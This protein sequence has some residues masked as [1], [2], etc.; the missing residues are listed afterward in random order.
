MTQGTSIDCTHKRHKYTDTWGRVK[1]CVYCN[2]P[3]PYLYDEN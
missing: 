1:R 2:K 3:N